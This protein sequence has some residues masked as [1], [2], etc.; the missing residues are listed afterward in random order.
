MSIYSHH[1]KI[2]SPKPHKPHKSSQILTNPHKS[3]QILTNHLDNYYTNGQS[4]ST[5]QI[6]RYWLHQS[7]NKSILGSLDGSGQVRI[8]PWDHGTFWSVTVWQS[9]SH[10]VTLSSHIANIAMCSVRHHTQ[11]THLTLC[12]KW[13]LGKF[14]KVWCLAPPRPDPNVVTNQNFSNRNFS[15]K[16]L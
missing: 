3:S 14:G 13:S 15:M 1:D 5:N 7:V 11:P 6:Q 16:L 8:Q 2:W 10:S 12:G 9:D 4:I